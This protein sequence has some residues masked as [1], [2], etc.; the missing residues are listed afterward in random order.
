MPGENLIDAVERLEVV[1][2]KLE[3]ILYGDKD[4]RRGGLID[5]FEGLRKDVQTLHA[6]VQ[7]LKA[8]R[9]NVWLWVGGYVAFMASGLFAMSAIYNQPQVQ[10]LLDMPPALALWLAV[11][12]A[13]AAL[14][15]FIGGFGWLDRG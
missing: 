3:R 1:S 14:L 15:L 6:D 13:G 2:A 9:P 4:A 10:A 8:R 11:A 5:E 12:L 7:R